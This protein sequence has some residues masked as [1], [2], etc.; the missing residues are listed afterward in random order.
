MASSQIVKECEGPS[1]MACFVC[2]VK[3]DRHPGRCL[4]LQLDVGCI[5]LIRTEGCKLYNP[6]MSEHVSVCVCVYVC[7]CACA[8]AFVCTCVCC[9]CVC[10]PVCISVYTLLPVVHRL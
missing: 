6:C 1:Y 2:F 7:V 10:L 9:H 8:R 4:P 5:P 3:D